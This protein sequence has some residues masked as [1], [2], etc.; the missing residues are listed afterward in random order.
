[1]IAGRIT[2]SSPAHLIIDHFHFGFKEYI[3]DEKKGFWFELLKWAMPSGA[4]IIATTIIDCN[5][6]QRDENLAEFKS[7]EKFVDLLIANNDSTGVKKQ[8]VKYYTRFSPTEKLK[9]DWI[10]YGKEIDA[11]YATK[12]DTLKNTVQKI[13]SLE[14]HA[15]KDT[16][17]LK[18][19]MNKRDAITRQLHSSN[20]R[21]PVQNIEPVFNPVNQMEPTEQKKK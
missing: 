18:V 5:S 13:A 15:A 11:E 10:A 21:I 6:R 8:L 19:L 7:Y 3:M 2:T 4:L 14:T 12:E 17:Q 9:N 1:M 20:V 16:A